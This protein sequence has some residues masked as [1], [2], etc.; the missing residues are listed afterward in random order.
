MSS[1]INILSVYRLWRLLYLSPYD[2]Y[3][4]PPAMG[5]VTGKTGHSLVIVRRSDKKATGR[6]GVHRRL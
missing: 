6:R 1:V 2:T 5:Y 3:R 4:H